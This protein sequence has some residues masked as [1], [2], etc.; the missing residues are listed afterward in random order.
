[1]HVEDEAATI[2]L[3]LRERAGVRAPGVPDRKSEI[4]FKSRNPQQTIQRTID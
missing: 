1:M 4:R 3:S 2:S